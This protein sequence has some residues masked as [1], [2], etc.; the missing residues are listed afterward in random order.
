MSPALVGRFLTTVPP[1][2]CRHDILS[3]E[4]QSLSHLMFHEREISVIKMD[5]MGLK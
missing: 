5:E 4:V 1:E 2:K 3:G